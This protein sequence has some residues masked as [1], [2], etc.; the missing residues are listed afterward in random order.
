MQ[1]EGSKCVARLN[2]LAACRFHWPTSIANE[3]LESPSRVHET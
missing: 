3:A 2:E 1:E